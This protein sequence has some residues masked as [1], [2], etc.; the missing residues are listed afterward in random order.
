MTGGTRG[1]LV[2]RRDDCYET[3]PAAVKAL[4]RVETLPEVIWECA[5]GP[6][7]IVRQLRE[8]GH[9]V[10]ATDLVD[11]GCP[12]SES[13]I[14]FLMERHPGFHVG[15]I[16]TNPPFKLACQFVTHALTLGVPQVFLLLRLGF[17]ES[18]SR[19]AV[20]ESRQLARIHVFRK[21][22]PMMH[23]AGWK[24]RRLNTSRDSHA[25]FCWDIRHSGDTV[26]DRISWEC[27]SS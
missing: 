3:P 24:G 18:Q 22:L 5:C 15:A 6:G 20:L 14:D 26:I 25:W 21:R 27:N 4:L 7:A 9:K 11:Y 8:V 2:A 10:Y 1:P 19:C 23:R 13:R 17:Y 16:V 12:D